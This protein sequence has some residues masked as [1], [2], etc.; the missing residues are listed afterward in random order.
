MNKPHGIMFHHFHDDGVHIKG[1]GSID[2]IQFRKMLLWLQK[3]FTLLSADIWYKKSLDNRL[4]SKDICITFD[5]NLKCQFD[6]AFPVLEE[7][8]LNAFW[9]IY[10]SPLD[11]IQERLEIYRYFRFSEFKSIEAFYERFDQILFNSKHADFVADKLQQYDSANFLNQ[12]PFYSE[13]DKKFRYIRDH[14]L[15]VKKYY[16]IMDLMIQSSRMDVNKVSKILWNTPNDIKRLDQ[17]GH[18]IGLHSHSHPTHIEHLSFDEQKKEYTKCNQIL[19]NILGKELTCMSHPC[20][21]YNKD[22]LT[23]LKE[24][25]I[26]LGFRAN[27]EEGFSSFLE[28]PRLDHAMLIDKI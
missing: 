28:Y 10:S 23:L 19:A 25:N 4:E 16:E 20:N 8:K 27:M 11:G 9:F 7:F 3:E 6:I 13:E 17:A 12:F 15:G 1:Q 21:S 5:D 24:M 22:T 18:I 26:S 14:I 2:Q